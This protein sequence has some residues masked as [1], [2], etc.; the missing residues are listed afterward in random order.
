MRAAVVL[1]VGAMGLVLATRSEGA[2][3]PFAGAAPNQ[4][5]PWSNV[6]HGDLT[7]DGRPDAIFVGQR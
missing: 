3:A 2:S 4:W 6:L 1:M 5:R 7:G